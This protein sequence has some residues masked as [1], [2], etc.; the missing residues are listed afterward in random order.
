MDV[1]LIDTTI[2]LGTIAKVVAVSG[3]LDCMYEFIL[4]KFDGAIEAAW[5]GG[6]I[7]KLVR[8][9]GYL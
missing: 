9:S 8:V 7:F 1:A 6:S 3:A 4:T 5:D 2:T